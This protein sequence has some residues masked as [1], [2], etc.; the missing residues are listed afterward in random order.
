M[1][2]QELHN[3]LDGAFDPLGAY[4]Q[5]EDK[6]DLTGF[7]T[8]DELQEEAKWCIDE[9]YFANA[10]DIIKMLQE[11]SVDSIFLYDYSTHS[12]NFDGVLKNIYSLERFILEEFGDQIK[13]DE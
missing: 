4:Y 7:V 9:G 2:K 12:F 8:Y 11:E 3:L 6:L 13:E 5:I 1:N 10:I